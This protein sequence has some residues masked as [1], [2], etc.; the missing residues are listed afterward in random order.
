MRSKR[1]IGEGPRVASPGSNLISRHHL[2]G[3]ANPRREGK[4][5]LQQS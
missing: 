4:N 2:E 3:I 5:S 1:R